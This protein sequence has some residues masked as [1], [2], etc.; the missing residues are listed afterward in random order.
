MLTLRE[1]SSGQDESRRGDRLREDD[2]AGCYA[3]GLQEPERLACG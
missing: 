1:F 3:D 2:E